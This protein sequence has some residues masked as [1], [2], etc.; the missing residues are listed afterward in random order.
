MNPPTFWEDA[1][2]FCYLVLS[3]VVLLVVLVQWIVERWIV[4]RWKK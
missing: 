2:F 4:E 3:V 1:A